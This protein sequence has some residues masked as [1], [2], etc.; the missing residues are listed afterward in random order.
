[1]GRVA[2]SAD[3]SAWS[4]PRLSHGKTIGVFGL[5]VDTKENHN[6]KKIVI[7]I[8]LS[9]LLI[10]PGRAQI[11]DNLETSICRYGQGKTVEVI[12]PTIGNFLKLVNL[13]KSEFIKVMKSHGYTQQEEPEKYLCYW[14]WNWYTDES[15]ACNTFC[16][17]LAEEEIRCFIPEDLMYPKD[18]IGKLYESLRGHKIDSKQRS[19]LFA[20]ISDGWVYWMIIGKTGTQWD[21]SIT[22][23][24][25]ATE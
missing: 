20:F 17:N 13:S 18:C 21:I 6:M 11:I 19:D 1:M 23:K 4:N 15:K 10:I 7:S 14:N 22:K 12:N 8:L 5:L 16:Y 2:T 9:L 3:E 25:K 24:K